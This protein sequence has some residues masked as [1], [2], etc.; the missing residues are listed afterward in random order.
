MLLRFSA[1]YKQNDAF[2]FDLKLKI[3]F[4]TTFSLHQVNS[5]AST[6]QMKDYVKSI[7]FILIITGL[8]AALT[9]CEKD[10]T[11]AYDPLLQS[12]VIGTW[13]LETRLINN[14]SDLAVACCDY[15]E[16][17][18]DVN[19]NDLKGNFT[20]SGTG[21]ENY[22]SFE[23]NSDTQSIRFEYDN[24]TLLYNLQFSDDRIIFTYTEDDADVEE[25]WRRQ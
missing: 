12:P 24:N 25:V 11:P 9:A 6:L 7:R 17:S 19:P 22:G 10:N 21:Y 3:N 4:R 13:K 23:I 16:F 18:T 5:F 20:A 14:L 1:G 15:L 2:L 8:L